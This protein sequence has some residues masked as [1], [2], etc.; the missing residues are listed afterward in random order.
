LIANPISTNNE[1][2]LQSANG[3]SIQMM[4]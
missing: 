2:A 1:I 3:V 4:P